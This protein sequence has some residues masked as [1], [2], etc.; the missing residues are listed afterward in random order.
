MTAMQSDVQFLGLVAQDDPTRFR[1]VVRDHLARLD[2]RLYG[3]T[4]IAASIACVA[5]SSVA[6][7][8]RLKLIVTAGNEPW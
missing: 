1:F 3:G 2:G 8:A 6:P 7:D 4:A 5:W